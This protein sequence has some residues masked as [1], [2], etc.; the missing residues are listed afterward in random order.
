M[1]IVFKNPS[2]GEFAIVNLDRIQ[3]AV[4]AGKLDA[5]GTV[6]GARLVEAGVLR[7]TLD[8]VR[9]LARGKLKAALM[10]EVVHASRKA[11]EAVERAGGK[12]V[13]L[14]GAPGEA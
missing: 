4:D 11:V 2:R 13:V 6:D 8:G 1:S 5:A 7:R 3:A 12:V 10:L 14:G 9:L